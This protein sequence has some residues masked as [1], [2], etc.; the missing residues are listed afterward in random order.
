MN[1]LKK[2]LDDALSGLHTEPDLAAQILEQTH[3]SERKKHPVRRLAV[4]AC[5]IVVCM[6][7]VVAAITTGISLS[8]A[9]PEGD[10]I[11]R[12]QVSMQPE[13]VT[14]SP[15]VLEKLE[16]KVQ[17]DKRVLHFASLKEVEEFLGCLLYTSP[18]PRD[19]EESR[20][21]SSA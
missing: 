14:L 7:A 3:H 10:E 9:E 4:A 11:S 5:L 20:M 12:Y 6:T 15:E 13:T 8:P 2:H 21:P 18:S 16:A 1:Q 19:V 17:A